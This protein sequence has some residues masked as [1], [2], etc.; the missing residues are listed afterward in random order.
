MIRHNQ[1]GAIAHQ[2][3]LADFYSEPAQLSDL[4]HQRD[5]IDNHAVSD[6]ANFSAA[7]NPGGNEMENISRAAVHDGV[8]CIVTSLAADDHIGLAR[9]HVDDFPFSFVAPLRAN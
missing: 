8:S 7:Q 2:K 1:V 9:K 6:D 3:V 5:R 4:G